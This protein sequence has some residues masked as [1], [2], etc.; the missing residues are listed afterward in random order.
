MKRSA[1]KPKN[2]RRKKA[3]FESDFGGA[4]YLAAIKAMPCAICGVS[5]FSEAAHVRS[6]GAGGKA[7]DL[8]PLCGPHHGGFWD[9]MQIIEPGCH[10]KFDTRR[11]TLLP[12]TAERLQVLAA[13]L[14]AEYHSN[15]DTK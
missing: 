9:D 7:S 10:S 4:E 5:G 6:R 1:L 14:Y 2:A 12:D 11:W 15:R 3:R 13:E 8:V